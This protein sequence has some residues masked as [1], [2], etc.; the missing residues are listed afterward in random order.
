[1]TQQGWER[2]LAQ[3]DDGLRAYLTNIKG[4]TATTTAYTATLNSNFSGI[5]N[6]SAGIAQYNALSSKG[7]AEQK[8]YSEAV[9]ASNS[10]FGKYLAGLNGGKASLI[11]Y[12]A[13]LVGATAKTVGLTVA[14]VALNAAL[15]MGISLVITGLVAAFTEWIQK[16]EQ[17]TQKAQEAADKIKSINDNLKTN[18]GTV[19]NAKK[20]YAELSQGVENLGK[21]NQSR[22][23]L[24]NEEYE[25]FLDLSNQLAGALPTLTKGYDYNGNALLNLSGNINTVI[26]SL[27]ELIKKEKEAANQDIMKEF[28]DVFSGFTQNLDNLKRDLASAQSEFNLISKI[29]QDLSNGGVTRMAFDTATN[30]WYTNSN[31]EEIK[32][33]LAEYRSALGQLGIAYKE[34]QIM[35]K[36]TFGANTLAGHSVEA[37]GNIDAAVTSK[38][39]SARSGLKNAR[40]QLEK[41]T[42][43]INQYL[44]TWLQTDFSYNQINDSGLQEAIQQIL[45]NFDW[46]SLPSNIRNDWGKVSEYLRQNIII[47]INSAQDDPAIS[48]SLSTLFTNQDLSPEQ[49]NNLIE[50]IQG[51]FGKDN[52]ISIFLQPQFEDNETTQKNIESAISKF[53]ED[54]KDA[55][56]SF[57]K[58]NSINTQEELDSWNE[59]TEGINSAEEAMNAYS[60]AAAVI[61]KVTVELSDLQSASQGIS[62]IGSAFKEISDNGYISL[63]TL[64]SLKEAT[65]L[66]GEEWEAYENKLMNAQKGTAEFNKLTSDLVNQILDNQIDLE[67]ITNAT[68]A[69]VTAIENKIAA[70]LRES[71]VVNA[72]AVAHEYLTKARIEDAIQI[73]LSN[74][75]IDENIALLAA[76]MQQL[77]YTSVSAEHL[78]SVIKIFNSTKL[79]VAD[80][81][82]ALADLALQYGDTTNKAIGLNTALSNGASTDRRHPL[83]V[84][85]EYGVKRSVSGGWAF[86]GKEYKNINDAINAAIMSEYIKLPDSTAPRFSYSPNTST[87]GETPPKNS[88]LDYYLNT[89]EGN[90]SKHQD[91]ARYINDLTWGLNNLVKTEEERL[92]IEDKIAEAQSKHAKDRIDDI[93]FEIER[94]KKLGD[95]SVDVSELIAE[96]KTIAHEEADRLRKAGYGENSSEIQEMQRIWMSADEEGKEYV[97]TRTPYQTHMDEAEKE[98]ENTGD[99][100][101]YFKALNEGYT[102]LAQSEKERADATERMTA[103]RESYISSEMDSI[104][105]M[106]SAYDVVSQAINEEAQYG[107]MSVDTF[108]QMLQIQPQML[109]MFTDENGA[110]SINQEVVN[111]NTA[112]KIDML[113]AE[114]SLA[115]INTAGIWL[116][117]AGSIDAAGASASGA[118]GALWGLVEAQLAAAATALTPEQYSQL[119]GVIENIKGMAESAKNGLKSGGFSGFSGGGGTVQGGGGGGG[120]ADPSEKKKELAE[121]EKEERLEQLKN[122][123][124]RAKD[125]IE[126]YN[127]SVEILD[128]GLDLVE[129]KDFATRYDILS[130]KLKET[131]AYGKAMADEFIRVANIVPQSGEE[132]QEVASRLEELGSDMRD[133]VTVIRETEKALMQLSIASYT[134][135]AEDGLGALQKE[136]DRFE[137]RLELLNSEHGDEFKY[138]N[139]ILDLERLLP[140]STDYDKAVAEKQELD[141]KIIKTEKKTQE[142]INK[143]VTDALERQIEDNAKAREEEREQLIKDIKELEQEFNQSLDN[144]HENFVGYLTDNESATRTSVGNVENIVGNASL[145]YPYPDISNVVAANEEVQGII[146]SINTPP[147]NPSSPPE[148]HADGTSYHK[149]GAALVG[150]ENFLKGINKPSPEMAI[151]PDGGMEILGRN[152]AEIRNLPRGTEVLTTDDTNELLGRSYASGTMSLN[153]LWGE[154]QVLFN[155]KNPQ[156]LN[157][158]APIS[159]NRKKYGILPVVEKGASLGIY[160]DALSNGIKKIIE[161]IYLINK[162]ND[163]TFKPLVSELITAI[164]DAGIPDEAWEE[165]GFTP[166]NLR[167]LLSYNLPGATIEDI[168][169]IAKLN[170]DPKAT[171][172]LYEYLN[173]TD[174]LIS[175]IYNGAR[176]DAE[177]YFGGRAYKR[178]VPDN[179]DKFVNK[180]SAIKTYADSLEEGEDKAYWTK[181]LGEIMEKA[182]TN[183]PANAWTMTPEGW[184]GWGD[185][186]VLNFEDLEKYINNEPY[187]IK[188]APEDDSSEGN[189]GWK[190]AFGFTLED[191]QWRYGNF[192]KKTDKAIS[193]SRL[194]EQEIIGLQGSQELYSYESMLND[195]GKDLL[196]KMKDNSAAWMD[197]DEDTRARLEAENLS[198]A[199][200]ISEITRERVA[201]DDFGVWYI[202]S[203]LDFSKPLTREQNAKLYEIAAKTRDEIG[204]Q[205]YGL[206][207][208]VLD[209]YLTWLREGVWDEET[210]QGYLDILEGIK[211]KVEAAESSAASINQTVMNDVD[212]ELSD[213]EHDV[214][215]AKYNGESTDKIIAYYREAQGIIHDEAERL[216]DAG[217]SVNSPEIQALQSRYMGMEDT[218][219]G[220][221][222]EIPDR[223]VYNKLETAMNKAEAEGLISSTKYYQG[224]IAEEEEALATLNA[225]KAS[226]L[227]EFNNTEEGSARWNKLKTEI[228][229][230]DD[231]IIQTKINMTELNNSMR[232]IVWDR[233]EFLIGQFAPI[234][235]ESDFLRDIIG[236]DVFFDDAKEISDTISKM[237]ENSKA[238][239]DATEEERANLADAN[240]E[241]SKEIASI[242][243]ETVKRDANGVWWI[244]NK[245]LYGY[246][247][248]MLNDKGMALMGLHGM[249]YNIYMEESLTY[250]KELEKIEEDIAKK[251]NDINLISRKMELIDLRNQAALAAEE[252]KQAI[253]DLVQ[254]GVDLELE[255]LSDLID[256]YQE[257][258]D[259]AKDLYDYQ[260]NIAKQTKN[261]AT[262]EKQ[263]AAYENDTSEESKMKVQKLKV[264]LEEAK[265]DL[266]ETEQDRFISEQ[267]KLLGK[268]YED[269]EEI[270]NRRM[271]NV[272][273]I[274]TDVVNSVNSNSTEIYNT[275]KEEAGNLGISLSKEMS[276]VWTSEESALKTY[277][278]KDSLIGGF[279]LDETGYFS[280]VST[281]VTGIGSTLSLIK[282][283]VNSMLAY[284]SGQ[285]TAYTSED[286]SALDNN[287]KNNSIKWLTASKDGQKVY[288]KLNEGAGEEAGYVKVNGSW[289]DKDGNKVYELSEDEKVKIIVDKMKANSAAWNTASESRQK[290][291][292]DENEMLAGRIEDITGKSLERSDA[293][294]WYINNQE[295]YKKYKTGG[296]ADYTG[297]AWLDGT[298]GK[299]ELVLNP[300]DT[301]AFMALTN[302]LRGF[303]IQNFSRINSGGL[304]NKLSGQPSIRDINIT[305]PI[306]HVEDY[307]DF[308]NQLK[309]DKKFEKLVQ[310]MSID[311]VNGS[312]S[313]AKNKF[314][315]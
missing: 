158:D 58:D 139:R 84:A 157:M 294:V 21:V 207:K 23:S 47:A 143:I 140:T 244:G 50:Q 209:E 238:W 22:G 206:Y 152:G 87:S 314:K 256:K 93:D 65:G 154:I 296:L 131:T 64:S 189:V 162:N 250:A 80:K 186:N 210:N 114:A 151:Y 169:E 277:F 225:R 35:G 255:A 102:K 187:G 229:A 218:I 234:K 98:F 240:L 283:D 26:A 222:A 27:D 236:E 121:K 52:P 3:S 41:E 54:G 110:L 18:T 185:V 57:F 201:K 262:L 171:E 231:A 8:A 1:M 83:I 89:V 125:M 135:M 273:A 5:K 221:L 193:E 46:S 31:G 85:N 61:D 269:Y 156:H 246:K 228:N 264:E 115:A 106:Q 109:A 203:N 100:E 128:F 190:P 258:L 315:W 117:E 163:K 51:Y 180:I 224:M 200:R 45:F 10:N 76:E 270:L 303:D 24:N 134:A 197:S 311:L 204:E 95:E 220:L 74:E 75:K 253:I 113:A 289:Y 167:T 15:S 132:A 96:K 43:S 124:D 287:M 290:D 59:L 126:R 123:L 165:I 42:S 306:E 179:L 177:A 146:N 130:E 284:S 39:E 92:D 70:T 261:I 252:E 205:G 153:S 91:G 254:E 239:L 276:N 245:E 150:D 266:E 213:I 69:E 312:S 127:K 16:S 230:V 226:L 11:G 129:E 257:S 101:K 112:A 212:D 310:S 138:T 148:S 242:T 6:I 233:T 267:G 172:Q 214:S 108:Q 174:K 136:L 271:D 295:L 170:L 194:K 297:L 147:P 285:A 105:A 49:K 304:L 308:V 191:L 34:T 249:D 195:E 107:G 248:G 274:V 184:D 9:A 160:D 14:S 288:E 282:D 60:T 281:Q 7:I 90:F 4:A 259:S 2:I 33:T 97:D 94:V 215:V 237:K 265:T 63:N 144:S 120:G 263:L 309:N 292:A 173:G 299:P 166:E 217:F 20:R 66:L 293:G 29:Y 307:N 37:I 44:N 302:T 211:E 227:E 86:D 12:G 28:P 53:G 208:I 99:Y 168:K 118:T 272:D 82:K 116:A 280:T 192:L 145:V 40:L 17:I 25:E 73:G 56:E 155:G 19:E 104:D 251:P 301:R 199:N 178:S 141:R 305:I 175:N 219:Q 279:L 133:N 235:K 71:G 38:L 247:N 78:N 68:E 223:T 182:A 176:D 30:G 119:E 159:I 149:G 260:K 161:L 196:Q 298:P 232:Q 188:P 13:S 291:L 72:T 300:D 55:L 142:T 181:T 275:L 268:L 81:I 79:S 202:G 313:L 286:K 103:A 278:G 198:H 137:Q 164:E 32:T 48:K 183:I 62:A 216:R 36:T 67:G 88:E 241:L 122:G 243:G 77:G 111:S